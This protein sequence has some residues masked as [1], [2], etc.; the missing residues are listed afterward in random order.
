MVQIL[1]D[2]QVNLG[3]I[4]IS[5]SYARQPGKVAEVLDDEITD[6][7]LGVAT[8]L[9]DT[10]TRPLT[11]DRHPAGVGHSDLNWQME[12]NGVDSRELF[13]PDVVR[14]PSRVPS[15]GSP[16]TGWFAGVRRLFGR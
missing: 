10:H 13:G 15:D 16:G 6:P 14:K 4:S 12:S 3:L 5:H 9:S 7:R 2:V 1:L 11:S 8:Q